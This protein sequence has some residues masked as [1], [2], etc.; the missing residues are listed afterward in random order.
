MQVLACSDCRLR[1]V[2]YGLAVF[3]TSSIRRFVH[4]LCITSGI[5]LLYVT[6]H[7]WFMYE[8]PSMLFP[9]P[10]N[11]SSNPTFRVPQ[12][13]WLRCMTQKGAPGNHVQQ[14]RRRTCSRRFQMECSFRL[15][16]RRHFQVLSDRVSM[17]TNG[18]ND[19]NKSHSASGACVSANWEWFNDQDSA[20]LNSVIIRSL[21][22]TVGMGSSSALNGIRVFDGWPIRAGNL[23]C[24]RVQMQGS[25]AFIAFARI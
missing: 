19:R 24:S 12:D 6:Y 18:A 14:L 3:M 2:K 1:S 25:Y 15:S 5:C 20:V 9:W 21:I 13:E 7:T 4:I 10:I 16:L 22:A 17:S 23:N 11:P 8:P